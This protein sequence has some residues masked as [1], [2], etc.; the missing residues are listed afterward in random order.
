MALRPVYST[1]FICGDSAAEYDYT[2]PDGY[3]ALVSCID[4]VTDSGVEGAGTIIAGLAQ[5]GGSSGYVWTATYFGPLVYVK[6]R[7]K[8][9]LTP[10]DYIAVVSFGDNFSC[11]AS[12]DLLSLP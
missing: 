11:S 8:I 6:F 2:C 5:L 4:V 12:G 10:G 9:I 3:V 1:Q 7:G